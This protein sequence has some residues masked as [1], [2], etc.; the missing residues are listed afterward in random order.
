MSDIL[1]ILPQ[2]G[3]HVHPAEVLRPPSSQIYGPTDMIEGAALAYLTEAQDGQFIQGQ[4]AYES[5]LPQHMP[6][7]HLSPES[8]ELCEQAIKRFGPRG[9]SMPGLLLP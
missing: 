5:S 1:D 6:Y 8:Q 9:D 7:N 4:K 3:C 2:H